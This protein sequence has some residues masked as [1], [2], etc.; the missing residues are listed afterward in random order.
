MKKES[1]IIKEIFYKLN[2]FISKYNWTE[3]IPFVASN[4]LNHPK[5]GEI[6]FSF[7]ISNQNTKPIKESEFYFIFR[8]TIKASSTHVKLGIGKKMDIE[9]EVRR[10]GLNLNQLVSD[11]PDYYMNL[12]EY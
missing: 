2:D 9:K 1:L 6:M 3:E 7:E 11:L 8:V 4:S 5:F 10:V 12:V